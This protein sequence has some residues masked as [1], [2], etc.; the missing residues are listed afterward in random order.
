[1]CDLVVEANA[2]S[3][4]TEPADEVPPLGVL[5]DDA[6]VVLDVGRRRDD[7]EQPGDVGHTAHPLELA[8]PAQL[9]GDGD[10]VDRPVAVVEVAMARKIAWW[11]GR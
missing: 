7:V 6:G 2:R 10:G 11:A 1:M 4:I 9:L 3:V 5:L 8:R